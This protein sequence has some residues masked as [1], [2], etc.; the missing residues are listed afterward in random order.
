MAR[1][2]PTSALPHPPSLATFYNTHLRCRHRGAVL[3]LELQRRGRG[4]RGRRGVVD[5]L[6]VDV[7]VRAEDGQ[8]RAL[9]RADH[10]AADATVTLL[11]TNR[12]GL[13]LALDGESGGTTWGGGARGAEGGG[14]RGGAEGTGAGGGGDDFRP[15]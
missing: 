1:E 7:F 5:H 14:G 2:D 11:A 13:D 3:E 9:F 8:S 10:L 6:A 15:V 12:R 4:K